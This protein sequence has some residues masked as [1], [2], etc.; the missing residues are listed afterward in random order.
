MSFGIERREKD[1][2]VILAPNGRL[3]LGEAL[4]TFRAAM[5]RL[6]SEGATRV[7]LDFRQ[8]DYIDSSG[9]GCLVVSHTRM[10]KAGGAM[11]LYGLNRR[12]LELMVVTKLSTVFRIAENEMDAV[13]MCYPERETK[14]FDILSF[15]EQQRKSRAKSGE[16]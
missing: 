15:V 1:G 5:E 2:V 6:L 16:E 7:V 14:A 10:A 4:E 11:P 3:T 13:N 12:A 8:V 9:L